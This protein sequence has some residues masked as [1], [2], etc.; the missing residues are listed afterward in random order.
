MHSWNCPPIPQYYQNIF[1]FLGSR[2]LRWKVHVHCAMLVKMKIIWVFCFITSTL[3]LQNYCRFL[4]FH[5]NFIT[6][7]KITCEVLNEST[8]SLLMFHQ[9]LCLFYFFSHWLLTEA[10]INCLVGNAYTEIQGSIDLKCAQRN[11]PTY[12][13]LGGRY[14]PCMK[15]Q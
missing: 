11:F 2:K 13:R 7:V 10:K 15:R 8:Q 14:N 6:S 5:R 1:W 9:T 4:F 12:W 3:Q